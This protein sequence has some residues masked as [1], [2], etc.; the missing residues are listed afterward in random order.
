MN[1]IFGILTRLWYF[2]AVCWSVGCLLGFLFGSWTNLDGSIDK[3][4]DTVLMW[5]LFTLP[6]AVVIH[7][8]CR[9]I[10]WGRI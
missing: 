1:V 6:L 10:V 4:R 7:R 5:A 8:C 2:T 3:S 9:W